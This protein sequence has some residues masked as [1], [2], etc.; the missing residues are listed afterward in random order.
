MR[1]AQFDDLTRHVGTIDRKTS[2]K[3]LGGTLAAAAIARPMTAEAKNN[4]KKWKKKCKKQV[5]PCKKFWNK[6]CG[7]DGNCKKYYQKCCKNLKKCNGNKYFKC[8]FFTEEAE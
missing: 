8:A 7:N 6:H 2:L 3:V 1:S 5:K 4:N